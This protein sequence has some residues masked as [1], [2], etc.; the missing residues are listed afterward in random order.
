[1]TIKKKPDGI[2]PCCVSLLLCL[3]SK[4]GR[5]GQKKSGDYEQKKVTGILKE[6][7]VFHRSDFR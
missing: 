5:R 7:R 6:K 1:V 4:E 2:F 3:L